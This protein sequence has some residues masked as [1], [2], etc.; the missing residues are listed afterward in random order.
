[1]IELTPVYAKNLVIYYNAERQEVEHIGEIVPD[2]GIAVLARAFGVKAI[3]LGNATRLVIASDQMY[4]VGVSQFQTNK[5]GNRFD[6]EHAAIYIV[7]YTA[8]EKEKLLVVSTKVG[9]GFCKKQEMRWH[10]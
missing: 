1:M 2:V 5:K 6:A 8:K 3:G 7:A 4:S 10:T 9:K